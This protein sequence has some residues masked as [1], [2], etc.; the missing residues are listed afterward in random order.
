LTEVVPIGAAL[1][2]TALLSFEIYNFNRVYRR[3]TGD[4]SYRY[5]SPNR[6]RLLSLVLRRHSQ[7][8][9]ARLQMRI[10]IVTVLW[11]ISVFAVFVTR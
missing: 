11:L 10:A 7:S 2:L 9:L 8:E 5:L 6:W 4:Q 1:A 3:V